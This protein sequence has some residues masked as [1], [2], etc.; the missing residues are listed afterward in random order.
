MR[1]EKDSLG[2]KKVPKIA[3]YGIQ[4]IR[5]IENFPISGIKADKIFIK[6]YVILKKACCLANEEL[7]LL[8]N[9]KASA[10]K[11][12]CDEIINGK[13][14]NEFP[15]DVFQAGAGTSFNM[16]MNEVIANRAEE[17]LKGKK[18]EY[19]IINPND[20]VN[21]AQSTNDTFPTAMRIAI[22]MKL[23]DFEI[24]I[25][26]LAKSLLKKG[27]EFDHIIKSGRT[28]LQ[29]AVP[30]RLGQE[31]TAYGLTI[32]KCLKNIQRNSE[33]LKELGIGGTAAGT[34]I[35]THPQYRKLVVKY[36]HKETKIK[37]TNSANLI[38]SMQSQ[39][40]LNFISSAIKNLAIEIYRIASDLRLLAS[41][42]NTG[43][44]EILLPAVQPGSSIM[45]G[46]I[47]PSILE[48]VNMVCLKIIG[49]DHTVSLAV[50]SGQMELN[51]Y[52]PLMIY[53]T[54]NSLEIFKNT[55]NIMNEKCIT[56]ITADKEKCENYAI[57][58]PSILTALN[59]IIGYAKTAEVVKEFI[60]NGKSI[61]EIILEKSILTEKQLEKVLD[62]KRLTKPGIS[63]I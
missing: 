22:L 4:T 36:L 32:E 2:E 43:F 7:K 12:A 63:K 29:D 48:C 26:N 62:P 44:A 47:N 31:F 5:A 46:K 13:F 18:G 6:S 55:I 41:G 52:M 45:P 58:S 54:L 53:E 30:I 35:N 15:V 34:G 9:K 51:V 38:E 25:N 50:A 3:Y 56:G 28:H 11:K 21:M 33:Y 57:K 61:K 24:A 10:I 27:K 14:D 16:N 20:D 19:K 42:P 17:I 49:S 37:F 40:E 39:K 23:Q 59:P 8:P 1:I 60:K